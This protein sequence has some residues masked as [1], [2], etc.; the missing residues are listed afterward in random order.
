MKLSNYFLLLAG[1]VFSAEGGNL[2]GLKQSSS[3]SDEASDSTASAAAADTSTS[4]SS[5]F[6]YW[7]DMSGPDVIVDDFPGA[8]KATFLDPTK[9]SN[10]TMSLAVLHLLPGGI[11]ELHWHPSAVEWGFVTQG[12]CRITLMNN[13]GQYNDMD[14]SVGDIWSFPASWGHA[15][16][17]IDENVGCKMVLFFNSPELPTYND[18]GLSEISSYFP[19]DVL[20]ENLNTPEDVVETFYKQASTKGPLIVTQ[21]PMP[22]PPM[23]QSTNPLP[24][25]PLI[26]ILDGTCFDAG[27]GGYI[28]EVRDDVFPFT[29]SMSGGLIQMAAGALRDIHWHP[30]ADEM[31]TVLKGQL[32][33]TVV[34]IGGARQTFTLKAGDVGFVPRGFA[35]TFEAVG[36]ETQVLLAFNDPNWQT[37]ELSTWLAVSPQYLT[38]ASLNTT[39]G[40][41]EGFPNATEDFIGSTSSA[42]PT[43]PTLPTCYGC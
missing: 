15:I 33:V 35:H 43:S 39:V 24:E 9:I 3:S 42:C 25:S 6:N 38:A 28:Y 10:N 2:R 19:N 31:H 1:T 22:P 34:G 17:G 21:G 20:S 29:K 40:V 7:F 14:A 26:N 5:G 23:A 30:N 18:L 32:K 8:G 4:S 37:Q 13:A 41:V 27:S 16:Q 12:T 36:E 11:R